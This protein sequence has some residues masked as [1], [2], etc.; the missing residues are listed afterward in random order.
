MSNE[1]TEPSEDEIQALIDDRLASARRAEIESWL[2]SN[3]DMAARVADLRAQSEAVELAFGELLDRPVPAQLK[4]INTQA[5]TNTGAIWRMAAM[6]ALVVVGAAGGWFANDAIN[7]GQ[8]ATAA[9]TRDAVRA[10]SMFVGEKR[11]AVEVNALEEKHLVA[12]LSRRLQNEL[13]A[14]DLSKQGYQ[15]VGGR[16]LPASVIGP[17]AQFMYETKADGDRITI[18]IEQDE[19][20]R[21][22][23]FEFTRYDGVSAFWWKDGPLAYVL[24]GQSDRDQLLELARATRQQFTP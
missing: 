21:G 6:I 19:T 3:P 11:H 16:L 24:I 5:P 1:I 7:P 23:D 22:N 14:P 15:L 12:W 2:V 20:G 10:H 4:N 8:E 9:F 17:A 18:Y 13:V